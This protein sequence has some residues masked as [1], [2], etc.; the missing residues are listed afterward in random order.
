MSS[1]DATISAVALTENI[2]EVF[3]LVADVVASPQFPETELARY[4]VQTR[5]QLMQQ[6]ANPNF[7]GQDAVSR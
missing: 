1:E 4:K 3:A 6:R 7:L 2:D 5:A